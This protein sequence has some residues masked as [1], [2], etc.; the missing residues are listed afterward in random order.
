MDLG[1][2][3]EPYPEHENGYTKRVGK[4]EVSDT[5]ITYDDGDS[6][7]VPQASAGRG[8]KAKKTTQGDNKPEKVYEIPN[9]YAEIP[10]ADYETL[11]QQTIELPISAT[12]QSSVGNTRPALPGEPHQQ[13]CCKKSARFWFLLTVAMS[14][15]TVILLASLLTGINSNNL[16]YNVIYKLC[17]FKGLL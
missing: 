2:Y 5:S 1:V 11:Q 16:N 4:R 14:T 7:Q 13:P 6:S 8:K 17:L 9:V 3:L 10:N 12:P 15:V